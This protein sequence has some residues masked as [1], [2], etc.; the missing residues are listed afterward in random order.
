GSPEDRPHARRPLPFSR[1]RGAGAGAR[2]RGTSALETRLMTDRGTRFSPGFLIASLTIT[3]T[4]GAGSGLF[5]LWRMGMGAEVP[6]SH[7]QIHAHSQILGF[8]ALFIMGI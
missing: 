3:L 8:A 7:R 1:A 4:L 6:V 2:L 5:Y